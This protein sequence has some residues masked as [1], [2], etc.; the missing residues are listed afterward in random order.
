MFFVGASESS[1]RIRHE[2]RQTRFAGRENDSN[3]ASSTNDR[4]LGY[5]GA[6]L[7][8]AQFEHAIAY[9]FRHMP[10]LRRDC[11]HHAMSLAEPDALAIVDAND[12]HTPLVG[13]TDD[14]NDAASALPLLNLPL[15]VDS[16]IKDVRM[17]Y[18]G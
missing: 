7:L 3:D 10:S 15:L 5:V 14:S 16:Y 12:H 13:G 18:P 8:T 2:Y 11:V 17:Q 6:L 4:W 1:S 9:L